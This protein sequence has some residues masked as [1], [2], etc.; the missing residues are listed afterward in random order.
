MLYLGLLALQ[1]ILGLGNRPKAERFAYALSFWLFGLLALYLIVN[2][3]YMT[4][5]AL[6][7]M[8]SQIDKALD[9]GATVIQI[10]TNG[11]FGPIVSDRT[12]SWMNNRFTLILGLSLGC[13][14]SRHFRYMD[15]S[16]DT[17]FRSVAVSTLLRIRPL[18]ESQANAKSVPCSLLN[19]FI[20]YLLITI[21]FTN[22]LAVYSFC[23][24]L[25]H[26]SHRRLEI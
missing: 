12:R 4:A 7:P 17:L 16:L 25:I 5:M 13:R 26:F 22:V 18:A 21:S 11:T 8:Q 24:K 23:S 1:I 20:Q 10:F 15:Y 3:L 19:S 14:S 6:C 9:K 2:T